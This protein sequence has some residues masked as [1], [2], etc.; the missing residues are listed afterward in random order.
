MY[1]GKM[2]SGNVQQKDI[3]FFN[4]SQEEKNSME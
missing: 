2:I 3:Y 1:G 4:C